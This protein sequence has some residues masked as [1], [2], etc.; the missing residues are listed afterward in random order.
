M[1]KSMT[2]D[3]ET[4]A[5]LNRLPAGPWHAEGANIFAGT[6]LV[7]SVHVT[8]NRSFQ[9]ASELARIIARL[10]DRLH[11][12]TLANPDVM[13]AKIEELEQDKAELEALAAGIDAILDCPVS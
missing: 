11:L 13:Q 5:E 10:P 1:S 6:V 3:E 8:V 4:K 9:Q 2:I 7:A 12:L